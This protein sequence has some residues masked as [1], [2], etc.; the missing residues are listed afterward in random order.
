MK[1]KKILE[2][3]SSKF[4]RNNDK[5]INIEGISTNSTEMKNNYIFGAIKGKNFNGEN[6]INSF[7]KYKDVVIVIS[8]RSNVDKDIKNKFNII[9]VSNVRSF[10]SDIAK[11]VY[12]NQID[13][14]IAVTGT[15]GKT[16]VADYTRQI[17]EQNKLKA[18][19]IGTLGI[20]YNDQKI[21]SYLTTPQ[22]IDLQKALSKL[23]KNG[24]KKVI[25]EASSIGI[26]Q[27]RLFP[28]KFNKIAFT[29]FSRDHLDYH[30]S[31]TKY[32]NSKLKLFK[33]H[34]KEGTIAILNSD[35]PKTKTFAEICSKKKIKI[36]DYGENA[37]FLRIISIKKKNNKYFVT[38]KLK[39]SK[40][41]LKLNFNSS[42]EI[43]NVY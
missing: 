24:C 30:E 41:L 10:I 37:S 31:M 29:N 20:I 9:I 7:S 15:N 23:S 4:I 36:L 26:D 38:I 8:K 25:V 21:N 18:S 34:S 32:L 28:I 42:F 22:S 1:L 16:S 40:Y 19:S 33:N 2:N 35:D 14:I 27:N 39:D 11:I 13:E 5:N 12:K 6:F 17:W 3:C 43:Y